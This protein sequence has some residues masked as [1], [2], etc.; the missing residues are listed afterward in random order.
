MQE[1]RQRVL[2]T[3]NGVRPAPYQK[4]TLQRL[5]P[6]ILSAWTQVHAGPPQIA[7]RKGQRISEI[8]EPKPWHVQVALIKL[9]F[10]IY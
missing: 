9:Y 7:Q 3:W 5:L 8:L 6:R 10:K 2:Q 4:S 1:L